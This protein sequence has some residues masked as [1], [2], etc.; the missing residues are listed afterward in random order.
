MALLEATVVVDFADVVVDIVVD[1]VV[2]VVVDVNV[3]VVALF[4]VT[5]TIYIKL[6]SIMVNMRLLKATV[7]F[8]WW[9]A[10][11]GWCQSSQ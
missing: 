4:V 2:N 1:A 10:G 8:L 3:D 5:D 9:L 11:S 7:D 6:W